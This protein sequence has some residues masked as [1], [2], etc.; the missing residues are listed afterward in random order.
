MDNLKVK[1]CEEHPW[2]AC[3]NIRELNT[4]EIIA[5]NNGT[6]D[7]SKLDTA[8]D[9]HDPPVYPLCPLRL[10]ESVL[11][12]MTLAIRHKLTG[13]ALADVIKLVDLHCIQGTQSSSVKTSRELKSYFVNPKQKVNLIYCNPC[14]DMLTTERSVCPVCCKEL[15][16][17]SDE[18]YF[19][20]LPIEDQLSKF[21]AR[22]F[23]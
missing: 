1:N 15:N 2:H 23:I 22:E 8:E 12:I 14:F 21:L 3:E 7:A 17:P 18:K 20:I 4:G 6:A 9:N 13:E 5:D 19:L 10:S 16:L 11:L